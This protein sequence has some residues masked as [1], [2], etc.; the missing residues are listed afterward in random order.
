MPFKTGSFPRS[1]RLRGRHAFALFSKAKHFGATFLRVSAVRREGRKVA[2]VAGKKVSKLAL[3]RNTIKRRLRELYRI[4][5]DLL[6]RNIW[7]M[8]IAKPEARDAEFIHL[9]RDLQKA[10]CAVKASLGNDPLD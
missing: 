5:R 1:E 3:E 2:F 4:H 10:F 8:I 9:D 7:L 6:P